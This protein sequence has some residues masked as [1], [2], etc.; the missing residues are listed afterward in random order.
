M[1]DGLAFVLCRHTCQVFLLGLRNTQAVKGFF[2]FGW[3]FVPALSLLSYGFDIVV[4]IVEINARE[5]RSPRWHRTLLEEIQT[6][7]AELAHPSWLAL[8]FGDLLDDLLAQSFF[9]L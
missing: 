4:D 6:L 3:D 2:N 8:H 1:I 9:G 5:V 7:K